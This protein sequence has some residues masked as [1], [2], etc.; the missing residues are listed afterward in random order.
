MQSRLGGLGL[1]SV[2][3]PEGRLRGH[4]FHYS[5]TETTLVPFAV[6]EKQSGSEGEAV[7]RH[8]RLTASYLHL[9]WPSSPEAAARLFL[10]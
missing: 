9:Y 8:G 5:V 1:Q 2:A 3:L 6:A 10:P 7:Y 4:A